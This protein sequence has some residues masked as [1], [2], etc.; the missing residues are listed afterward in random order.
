MFEEGEKDL[1]EGL[2]PDSAEERGLRL[3]LLTHLARLII[4]DGKLK[5]R[6]SGLGHAALFEGTVG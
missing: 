1:S 6:V 2:P 4:E 3:L 5:G